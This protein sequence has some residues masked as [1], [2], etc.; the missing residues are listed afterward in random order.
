MMTQKL[1]IGFAVGVLFLILGTVLK[2]FEQ[3]YALVFLGIGLVISSLVFMR[4][5]WSNI[6]KK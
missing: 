2:I 1:L 4:F 3:E 6:K 5:A